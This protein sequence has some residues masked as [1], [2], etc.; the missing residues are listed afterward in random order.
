MCINLGD[1]WFISMAINEL[2]TTVLQTDD[3]NNHDKQMYRVL[4]VVNRKNK[5]SNT[6]TK[7]VLTILNIKF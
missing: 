3:L 2:P 4:L 5:N 6:V 7:N 1:W